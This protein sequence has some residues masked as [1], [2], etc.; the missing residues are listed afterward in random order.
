MN[1]G[2]GIIE[3]AIFKLSTWKRTNQFSTYDIGS[4]GMTQQEQDD[5]G[6]LGQWHSVLQILR[7]NRE[8]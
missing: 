5:F 8:L 7:F 6:V 2:P 3:V 1:G 4:V